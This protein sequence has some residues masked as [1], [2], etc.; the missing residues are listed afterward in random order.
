CRSM[1]LVK[2]FAFDGILCTFSTI[3]LNIVFLVVFKMGIVGYVFANIFADLISAI[4]L[5]TYAKLHR[6]V[7]FRKIEKSTITGMLKYAIPLIPT[8]IFWW[9]TNVSD[10]YIVTAME[11]ADINGL[12]AV[13]NKIPSMLVLLSTV[14]MEAWQMSAITENKKGER[15]NF[16]KKVFSSYQSVVFIGGAFLILFTKP[17]TKLLVSDSFYNA[18]TYT[19]FL[20]IAMAC[21]CLATFMGSVYVVEK[22]SVM[23]LVTTMTGAI[24]NIIMNF[25]LVPRFGANGAA[26]ATF[27]SYLCVFVIRGV[28]TKRFISFNMHSVQ[29]GINVAI[30]IIQ[31]FILIFEIKYWLLIEI[32]LVAAMLLINFK[33]LYQS[34][35]T[36]LKK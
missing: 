21:S 20:I 15:E 36:L 22:K 18:W 1:H 28:N 31:S 12:Y 24:L 27:M 4:F 10:R 25:I 34:I 30:L 17:I 7:K 5:F 35:R 9:I 3:V 33:Y 29:V 13:A 16:F 6:F 2:L 8:N 14:F 26:F 19:P 32:I 23:S 11:G